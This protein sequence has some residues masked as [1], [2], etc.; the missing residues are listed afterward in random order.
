MRTVATSLALLVLAGCGAAEP[1]RTQIDYEAR[2]ELV[3]AHP[4]EFTCGDERHVNR[5]GKRAYF[6]LADTERF[7]RMSRLRAATSIFLGVQQ[8]CKGKPD[9]YEPMR[10]A[11]AGVRA[12]RYVSTQGNAGNDSDHGINRRARAAAGPRG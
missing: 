10:E 9:A 1:P 6:A 11:V 7:E 3:T 5:F 4:Y 2:L 8:V 12:G